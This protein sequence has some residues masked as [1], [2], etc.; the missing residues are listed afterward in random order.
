[1]SISTSVHEILIVEDEEAIREFMQEGLES[2]GD[3]AVDTA[4][5]AS[6]VAMAGEKRYDVIITDIH[7]ADDLDALAIIEAIS[8]FDK[9][10]RFIV[11]TGKKRLDIASKLVKALKGNQVASFLFKPFD[12]EEICIAIHHALEQA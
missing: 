11:M 8:A 4:G 7:L 12:L 6:A 9:D 2:Y 5:D 3:F 1:M 10:V